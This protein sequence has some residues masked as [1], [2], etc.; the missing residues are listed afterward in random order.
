MDFRRPVEAVIP[1]SRG[2]VLAVLAATT[3]ELNLRTIARLAG[4]S[5]AQASR[6][7]PDLVA[8]GVV[9]R[10]EVPPSPMLRLVPE[11]VAARAL[12]VLVDARGVVAAEMARRAA[13]MSPPPTSVVV[14]GSFARGDDDA[15][16]DIDVIVVRPSGREDDEWAEQLDRWRREVGRVAGR[17]V[18]VVDVGAD[19]A[20][21]GLSSSRPLW[22][23]VRRDGHV[24]FGQ[25][26]DELARSVAGTDA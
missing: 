23:D 10:R 16:S 4:I 2:R 17:E 21:S 15:A 11:H 25:A 18:E 5:V 9:E 6:V 1:G 20:S 24:V 19:E 12:A 8:L 22:R 7:L 26:V 3:A 14:F 13:E